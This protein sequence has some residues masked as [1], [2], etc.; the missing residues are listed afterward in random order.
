MKPVGL[1]VLASCGLMACHVSN[2]GEWSQH[3]EL[4]KQYFAATA[5]GDSSSL[6]DLSED[7]RAYDIAQRAA[8]G[9]PD[10]VDSASRTPAV[11]DGYQ[12]S[13]SLDIVEFSVGHESGRYHFIVEFRRRPGQ[14]LVRYVRFPEEH[15][16]GGDS[17]E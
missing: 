1:A 2:G 9:I 12:L 17:R 14:L 6:R 4:V 15:N 8:F 5:A 11:V 3:I 7:W 13:D 10:V 16:D